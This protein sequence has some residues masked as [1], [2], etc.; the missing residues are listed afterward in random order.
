MTRNLITATPDT[1]ILKVK[2]ILKEYNI[3]Q[4]PVVEGRKLVGIITDKDIR[5]NSA[6]PASTLSIHELNY[7]LSE[8][9]VR[10]IMTKKLYTVSP[11]TTIEEATKLINEKRVNSLPV[12]VGDEL[13]GII[14]TCD[15][16]NVLLDFM[17]MDTPS[18]RVELMLSS[19]MGE[20][21]KIAGIINKLGLTIM[22]IVS[23]TN[24][25]KG[26]TRIAV[27]RVNTDDITELS[28]VFEE[29]GYKMTMEY[30]VE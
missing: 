30:K 6:S 13:F 16:L 2:N 4:I 20:I 15:L 5:D 29:S 25:E 14:T 9:K 26:D 27:I 24:R 8:M 17:G 10:E 22:S 7:L 12:V 23:T 28:K 3:D 11:G 1:S 21:A 19:D 18:S